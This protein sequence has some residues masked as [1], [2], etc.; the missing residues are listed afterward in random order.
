MP[1]R[2]KVGTSRLSEQQSQSCEIDF[3]S[4]PRSQKA[5]LETKVSSESNLKGNL[6]KNIGRWERDWVCAVAAAEFCS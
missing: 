1:K 3:T 4:S 6:V 2:A 5:Q